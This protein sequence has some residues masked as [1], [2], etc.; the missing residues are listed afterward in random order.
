MN[1][2]DFSTVSKLFKTYNVEFHS[3]TSVKKRW[4]V[5]FDHPKTAIDAINIVKDSQFKLR[6]IDT[7]PNDV[8]MLKNDAHFM[9]TSASITAQDHNN[10]L[11]LHLLVLLN[12]HKYNN[13]NDQLQTHLQQKE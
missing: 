9:H 5:I 2:S 4:F 12:N 11:L 3:L 6:R 13:N 8:A 1:A 10:L 7:N